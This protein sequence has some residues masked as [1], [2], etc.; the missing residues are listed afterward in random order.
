MARGTILT[1]RSC[2]FEKGTS[3]EIGG[4]PGLIMAESGRTIHCIIP[5][6]KG[7]LKNLVG[8]NGESASSYNI[9]SIHE[10]LNKV[11]ARSLPEIC[12]P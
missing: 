6:Q 10:H 2:D 11:R 7:G 12:I 9:S 4:D 3:I 1:V 8:L 5:P